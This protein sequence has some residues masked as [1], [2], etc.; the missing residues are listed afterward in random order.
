MTT[1]EL[2]SHVDI[3]RLLPLPLGQRCGKTFAQSISA[4]VD[5]PW[6]RVEPNK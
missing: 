6:S 3:V 1:E 5:S 4:A 2:N